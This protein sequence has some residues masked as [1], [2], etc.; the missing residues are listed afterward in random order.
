MHTY[1]YKGECYIYMSISIYDI[2]EKKEIS[3]SAQ[4]PHEAACAS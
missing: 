2:P 3:L 4:Q 1:I